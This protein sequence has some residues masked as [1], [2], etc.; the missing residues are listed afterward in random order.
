[1]VAGQALAL[2]GAVFFTCVFT[3]FL[4]AGEAAHFPVGRL[5]FAISLSIVCLIAELYV[6]VRAVRFLWKLSGRIVSHQVSGK[7]QPFGSSAFDRAGEL[8]HNDSAR[9]EQ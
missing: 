2:Q 9:G 7:S 8:S 4:F 1:M 6:L 3:I 5:L